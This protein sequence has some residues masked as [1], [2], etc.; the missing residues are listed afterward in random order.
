MAAE[1]QGVMLSMCF[2]QNLRL[3]STN[4]M[5]KSLKKILTTSRVMIKKSDA[6]V[7]RV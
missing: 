7:G 6:L 2:S 1:N 4:L 5:Q 3:S